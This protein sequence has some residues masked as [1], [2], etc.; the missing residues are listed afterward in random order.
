M[1]KTSRIELTDGQRLE[2]TVWI[3]A[4]KTG[5]RL[6]GRARVA[7]GYAAGISISLQEMEKKSNRQS[8]LK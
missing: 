1:R 6:S 7:L 2:P 3:T 4:G 5:Q 8:C